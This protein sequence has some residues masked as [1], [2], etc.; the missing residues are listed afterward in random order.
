MALHHH[1][2]HVG[3]PSH[4]PPTY[5]LLP[6]LHNHQDTSTFAP[7]SSTDLIAWH[8]VALQK[9]RSHLAALTSDVYGMIWFKQE[10]VATII[11]YDF[12][13][14]DLVLI[15]N[16]TIEKSLNRKMCVRYLSP[17]IVIS[18]NKGG[19]YIISKLD[20][21]VFNHPIA[22]F[23]VIPYF[24]HQHIDIPPLNELIDIS[25][26]RLCELKNSTTADPDEEDA[27]PDSPD[28]NED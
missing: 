7:L 3:Q 26:C 25:T 5:G 8:T 16:T 13:L 24:T 22:A 23:R 9:R 1:F 11:K 17:L 21:L 27:P 14:G 20:R 19:T 6:I 10:H 4:S 18:Q 28:G 12:K 15:R 2:H